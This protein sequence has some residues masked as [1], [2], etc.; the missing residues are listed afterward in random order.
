VLLRLAQW[1]TLVKLVG[2]MAWGDGHLR[3]RVQED[4][5][6]QVFADVERDP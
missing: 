3:M 4:H 2:V 6:V 5:A 1:C